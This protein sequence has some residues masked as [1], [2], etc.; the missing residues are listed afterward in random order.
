MNAKQLEMQNKLW[1]KDE[2]LK[3]LKAIVTESSSSSGSGGGGSGSGSGSVAPPEKPERPLREKDRNFPQRRSPSPHCVSPVP[4]AVAANPS[5]PTASPEIFLYNQNKSCMRLIVTVVVLN[6]PSVLIVHCSLLGPPPTPNLHNAWPPLPCHFQDSSRT[7]SH[8]IRAYVRAV[9][10]PEPS[11]Y[12]SP[13]PSVAS[14]ISHWEQRVTGDSDSQP[15]QPAT[16]QRATQTPG[17]SSVG[18]RRGQRYAPST[19]PAVYGL[20]L[21]AGKMVSV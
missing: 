12:S 6:I 9:P 1:V 10:E 19:T 11:T 15:W 13:Y 3:Q 8:Q 4:S 16:P 21:E 2:K 5:R 17:T 7:P 18:R 14:S 20:D